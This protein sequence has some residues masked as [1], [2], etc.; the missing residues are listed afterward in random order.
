MKTRL[1]FTW[2][3]VSWF[4]GQSAMASTFDILKTDK[5]GKM[6]N[7]SRSICL[8][9]DM[10]PMI[11]EDEDF[12]ELGTPI[13]QMRGKSMFGGDTARCTGTLISNDL[14][15]TARHC[16]AP[17]EEIT[18][19]FNFHGDKSQ[20][21]VFECAEV[22]EKGG[23]TNEDDYAILRLKGKPGVNWGFYPPASEEV[24]SSQ[25]L[26]MIHHP[27]GKPMQVSWE[28]CAVQQTKGKMLHHRCDTE[29]GSSGSGILSRSLD[30]YDIRILGVHTLGGC[31]TTGQDS[32]NSG[33]M[34]S[35]LLS[36]SPTLSE[37]SKKHRK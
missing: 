9:N 36:L 24:Q 33:P 20:E 23:P 15:L 37:L 8:T 13:G 3:V 29:P 17:C 21:E 18:V 32:S 34:M 7:A 10:G 11:E 25:E 26:M 35:H 12:Q 31:R 5:Y 28:E 16:L 2:L 19:A 4:A 27:A 6:E 22:V 14:F 1:T 30:Y